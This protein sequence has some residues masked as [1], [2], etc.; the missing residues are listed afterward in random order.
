MKIVKS[1]LPTF[2]GIFILSGCAP[3]VRLDTP[4]PVKINV[5]MN[6][7]VTTQNAGQASASG[8]SSTGKQ[9]ESNT[10][11]NAQ[12]SRRYRMKEIQQLKNDRRVGE[13]RDGL[14]HIINRPT[15]NA[16]YA[17][18]IEKLVQEENQDRKNLFEEQSKREKK[19]ASD[20]SKDFAERAIQSSFPGEWIQTS[21]GDWKTR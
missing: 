16:Q 15:D 17:S 8:S 4:E 3:T 21:S 11:A 12:Q 2:I 13:G 18:Y 6:V 9:N 10:S 1:I 14:L 5:D 20:I 19:T 7:N